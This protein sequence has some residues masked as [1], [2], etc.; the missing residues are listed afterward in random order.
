M[1][2]APPRRGHDRGGGGMSAD[3][4]CVRDRVTAMACDG[5]G[6]SL[7]GR[8][9]RPALLLRGL[10]DARRGAR[11]A[12][13]PGASPVPGWSPSAGLPAAPHRR[14]APP[15]PQPAAGASAS[16]GPAPTATSRSP[17]GPGG[18]GVI[19]RG[20]T[21]RPGGAWT[22]FGPPTSPPPRR[23]GRHDPERP[24]HVNQPRER[25]SPKPSEAVHASR[26]GREGVKKPAVVVPRSPAD[27]PGARRVSAMSLF[28]V[29][30]DA[31]AH[32]HA[33]PPMRTAAGAG[34]R[35]RCA[36]ASAPAEAGGCSTARNRRRSTP[37]TWREGSRLS[38]SCRRQGTS[39]A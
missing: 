28:T 19:G 13:A 26:A 21:R 7:A 17:F 30:V 23:R 12:R 37:A 18:A 34:H 1:V 29:G 10:P 5:C 36:K 24:D 9:Q 6:R 16:A 11:A 20:D 35:R 4:P 31:A 33:E 22:A 15:G 14:A 32:R 38:M 3:I 2:R 8:A 39:A 27:R 25:A